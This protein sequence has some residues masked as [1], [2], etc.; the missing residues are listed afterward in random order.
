MSKRYGRK[1]K[2]K[3]RKL[4]A[5]LVARL[6]RES[7]EHMY[8]PRGDE[9]NLEDLARVT[10]YSVTELG[11]A[12]MMIEREAQVTVEEIKDI[13]E[14]VRDQTPVQ[15]QG[16]R[17][18]IGNADYDVRTRFETFGGPVHCRLSLVGVAP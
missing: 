2:F 4:I 18:I 14:L 8:L 5:E 17:Y 12:S 10:E 16:K 13:Y 15:F 9:P 11:G 3:H 6:S 7:T 1:Q